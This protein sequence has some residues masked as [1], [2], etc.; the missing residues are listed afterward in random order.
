MST[1]Q[2]HRPCGTR[3]LPFHGLDAYQVALLLVRLAGSVPS[4]RG[5][6]DARDQLRRASSSVALNIAEASGK[7]GADRRRFFFIARG[8]ACE[9]GAALDVLTALGAVEASIHQQGLILCDRLY[10]MLTRLCGK[11]R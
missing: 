1:A 6:A 11:G 7:T 5:A 8:S 9:A 10:A 3:R 2:S 4:A